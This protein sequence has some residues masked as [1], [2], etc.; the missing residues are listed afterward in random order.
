MTTA[1]I[2]ADMA[3]SYSFAISC[4]RHRMIL[5][6]DAFPTDDERISIWCLLALRRE[7]GDG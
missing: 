1:E 3:Q 2:H 6:L 7:A 5:D 4:I